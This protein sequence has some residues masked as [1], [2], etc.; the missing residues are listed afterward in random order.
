MFK[1]R[2][3]WKGVSLTI[4]TPRDLRIYHVGITRGTPMWGRVALSRS[5]VINAYPLCYVHIP[6]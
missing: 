3:G 6:R 1:L 4:D 5:T 2:V